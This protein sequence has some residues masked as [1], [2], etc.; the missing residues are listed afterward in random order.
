MAVL[1]LSRMHFVGELL[2]EALRTKGNVIAFQ[3][4]NPGVISATARGITP[5]TVVVDS[6]HPDGFAFVSTIRTQFPAVSLVVIAASDCEEDFLAWAN[7]GI[8]SY[9]APETP[10]DELIAIIRR[11]AAGEVFCPP[12]L[13]AL[14][15][16]RFAAKRGTALTRAGVHSLTRREREVLEFLADGL[17]NKLIALRL[18]IAE[19]TVKNHVHSILE[20]WNLPSRGEAAARFR[21]SRQD[22]SAHLHNRGPSLAGRLSSAPVA[23]RDPHRQLRAASPHR[24]PDLDHEAK[25]WVG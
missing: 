13:T 18:Q 22:Q 17:S 6:A 1:I 21:D 2:T 12:R 16:S 11:S 23:L 3:E 9:V 8:S 7:V 14:L 4:R 24:A 15:L 25:R 10:L 20:K 19:A 5:E